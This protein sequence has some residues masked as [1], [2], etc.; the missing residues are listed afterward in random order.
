MLKIY[1]AI[2]TIRTNNG[3]EF[4]TDFTW[5]L[6]DLGIKHKHIPPRRPADRRADAA[7]MIAVASALP[8]STTIK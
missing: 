8:S 6:H 1:V 3:S 5:H 7:R 4:G 2:Q